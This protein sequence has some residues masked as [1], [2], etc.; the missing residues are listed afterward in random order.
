MNRARMEGFEV[1]YWRDRN[2]EIDF[3]VKSKEIYGIEVKTSH[4]SAKGMK[5]FRDKF[6]SAKVILLEH[7]SGDIEEF[8]RSG[9]LD[10]L[11]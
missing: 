1:F 3:V 9:V 10:F 8:L 2:K 5:P 4:R 7:E 6:P 11:M